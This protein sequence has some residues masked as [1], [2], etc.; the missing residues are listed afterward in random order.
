MFI[1]FPH[2]VAGHVDMTKRGVFGTP[3]NFITYPRIG[4]VMDMV[5]WGGVKSKVLGSNFYRAVP[6]FKSFLK[7]KD[8]TV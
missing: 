1:K 2:R 7:I 3:H 6:R 5:G 4:F 8:N